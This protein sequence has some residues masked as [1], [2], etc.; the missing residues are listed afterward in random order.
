[1][2]KGSYEV[3][4]N[5]GSTCISRQAAQPLPTANAKSRP[6]NLRRPSESN[7]FAA[8]NQVC[9]CSRALFPHLRLIL[10]IALSL[11]EV[12]LS[13]SPTVP[14]HT[15]IIAAAEQKA[16]SRVFLPKVDPRTYSSAKEPLLKPRAIQA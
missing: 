2:L 14:F 11:L 4:I 12:I 8:F 10:H 1:M 7:H 16:P 15:S 5:F 13:F 3:T 9:I 6:A